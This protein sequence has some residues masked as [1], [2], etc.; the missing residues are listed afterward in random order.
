[1]TIEVKG[2]REEVFGSVQNSSGHKCW[3]LDE[4]GFVQASINDLP[5][6]FLKINMLMDYAPVKEFVTL[7]GTHVTLGQ[8]ARYLSNYPLSPSDL[9]IERPQTNLTKPQ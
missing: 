1:M 6:S 5:D 9:R 4:R 3:S 2:E 8:K 7:D